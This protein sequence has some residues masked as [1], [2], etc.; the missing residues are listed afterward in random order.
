MQGVNAIKAM[1]AWTD[2]YATPEQ[3]ETFFK[4]LPTLADGE[5]WVWSPRFLKMFERAAWAEDPAYQQALTTIVVVGG[6]PTGIEL[7][8]QLPAYLK[9]IAIAHGVKA[10][11]PL[12]PTTWR[13]CW[14]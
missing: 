7:A 5:C 4:S 10:G 3:A 6:G 9:K 8:G 12:A 11:R 2:L 1:R 14:M 13:R